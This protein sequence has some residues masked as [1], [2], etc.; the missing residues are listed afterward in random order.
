MRNAAVQL[1]R[2]ARKRT[3]DQTRR[4]PWPRLLEVRTQ[5]IDW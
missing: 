1:Q 2:L 5:Y 4:I 3:D